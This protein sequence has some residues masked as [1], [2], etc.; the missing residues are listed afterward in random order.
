MIEHNFSEIFIV[1]FQES[2][3][4]ILEE[5]EQRERF[6]VQEGHHVPRFRQDIDQDIV[7]LLKVTPGNQQ[8]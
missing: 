3:C 7:T 4:R 5:I 1:T 6:T 2:L 8:T